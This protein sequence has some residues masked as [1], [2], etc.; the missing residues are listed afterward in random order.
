M[1]KV[2]FTLLLLLSNFGFSQNTKISFSDSIS[3][4]AAQKVA[5]STFT[6]IDPPSDGTIVK[7][8]SNKEFW[9]GISILVTLIVLIPLLI[10]II[11]KKNI[12]DDLSVKLLLTTIVIVS[13]LFLVVAGYDDK[14]IAP[15]FGLFGAILGYVFGKSENKESK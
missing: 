14:T 7:F 13:T 3:G 4:R 15:A 8:S 5:D 10:W 9:F 1:K 12:A 2:F 11:R 6:E